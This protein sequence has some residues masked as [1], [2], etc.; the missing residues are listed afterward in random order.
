MH[1]GRW[2]PYFRIHLFKH[3]STETIKTQLDCVKIK[4][5][6][7]YREKLNK[8]ANKCYFGKIT[9]V[10][11]LD[12]YEHKEWSGDLNELPQL[13]FPDV[14]SYLV[15]SVSAYTFKQLHWYCELFSA[16]GFQF[17]FYL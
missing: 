14:F 17:R 7:P 12:P 4:C 8:E 11:R 1:S 13:A 16:I 6:I 15:C 9:E 2:S 10:S 3:T 5:K